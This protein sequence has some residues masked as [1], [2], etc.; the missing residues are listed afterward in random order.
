M[1]VTMLYW[2]DFEVGDELRYGSHVVT[3][4]DIIEFGREFDPQ[5]FHVDADAAANGPYGGLIASGWQTAGWC[6]RMMVDN[7]LHR[8][9]SM[10]SPGLES[11]RW[12]RP[13]R[14]GDTLHVI[15]RVLDRRASRSRPEMGLAK[16]RFEV[17]NQDD[18]VVMVM[19]SQ[20]MFKRRAGYDEEAAE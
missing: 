6:M 11:L 19:V 5:P 17:C 12:K 15:S 1:A 9:A 20:S 8:S 13:V 16:M 7:V 4:A 10:G 2:E 14:P 18:E 3:E